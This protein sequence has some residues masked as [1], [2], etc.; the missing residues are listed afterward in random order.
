MLLMIR[1]IN[2]KWNNNKIKISNEKLH[3]KR[4]KKIK[5][6]YLPIHNIYTLSKPQKKKLWIEMSTDTLLSTYVHHVTNDYSI[7]IDKL[8]LQL[9]IVYQNN[10]FFIVLSD[11]ISYYFQRLCVYLFVCSFTSIVSQLLTLQTINI[12]FTIIYVLSMSILTN[13][14]YQIVNNIEDQNMLKSFIIR[15]LNNILGC[16]QYKY[17]CEYFI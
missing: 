2:P 10:F 4:N 15:F 14:R 16:L 17:I 13:L 5:R 1:R 9:F 12:N 6:K 8:A 7:Y 3:S 11:Y